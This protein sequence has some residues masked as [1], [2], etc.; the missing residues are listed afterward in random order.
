MREQQGDPA[1][2]VVRQ[3]LGVAQRQELGDRL[4]VLVQRQVQVRPRALQGRVVAAG[5]LLGLLEGE[6]RAGFVARQPVR[7]GE[8]HV[9]VRVAGGQADRLFEEAHRLVWPAA[10]Q[11]RAPVGEHLRHAARAL[12]VF[13]LALLGAARREHDQHRCARPPP[14]IRHGH[15]R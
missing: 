6:D 14:G 5:Q 1:Q 7:L 10:A 12:L 13:Q 8:L 2:L 4:F 11:L 15:G 3:E 9:R